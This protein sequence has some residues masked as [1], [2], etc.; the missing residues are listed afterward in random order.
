LPATRFSESTD[1]L[2]QQRARFSEL[3]DDAG[4]PE[5]K[6]TEPT[7]DL[8]RQGAR[9]SELADDPGLQQAKFAEPI[10]DLDWQGARFAKPARDSEPEEDEFK[11]SDL[12]EERETSPGLRVALIATL[13]C[14]TVLAIVG[15]NAARS[16]GP[17]SPLMSQVTSWFHNSPPVNNQSQVQ[18][19]ALPQTP[20]SPQVDQSTKTHARRQ[21]ESAM[22]SAAS[23]QE[24]TA[25]HE[26]FGASSRAFRMTIPN[27]GVTV[28][29]ARQGQSVASICVE[30]FNGCTPELLNTIVELN[31][32]I[33]DQDHLEAGQRIFL[34]AIEP[35]PQQNN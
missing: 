14:A 5:I 13:I 30:R 11:E 18:A 1:G 8:G 17:A 26:R 20:A 25:N 15:W 4:L 19:P 29:G 10:D 34:P 7:D 21:H 3:A 24:D 23:S 28:V 32:G 35:L 22:Q 16:G 2:G 9:F 31:P 27:G 6:F 33:K 12:S